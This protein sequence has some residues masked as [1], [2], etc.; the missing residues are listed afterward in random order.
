ME[1]MMGESEWKMHYECIRK[2]ELERYKES[3]SPTAVPKVSGVLKGEQESASFGASNT[4]IVVRESELLVCA[5][6]APAT[7]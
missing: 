1:R 2:E 4:A 5:E 3:M 6:C 7:A